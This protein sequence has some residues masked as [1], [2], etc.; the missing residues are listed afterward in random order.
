MQSRASKFKIQ[1][2]KQGLFI[3]YPMD[4]GVRAR[5]GYGYFL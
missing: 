1:G 3:V 2:Y 5:Q 4:E